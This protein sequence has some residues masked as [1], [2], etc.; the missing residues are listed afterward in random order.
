MS[1]FRKKTDD[2][3]KPTKAGVGDVT[4]DDVDAALQRAEAIEADKAERRRER[5]LKK[6]HREL[7]KKRERQAKLV[8]PILL[9]VSVLV[10]LLLFLLGK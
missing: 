9:A 4:I 2:S 1:W 5:Q 3:P 8:A 7:K 6:F 10:S